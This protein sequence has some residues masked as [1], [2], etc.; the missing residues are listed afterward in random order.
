[1]WQPPGHIHSSVLAS[2]LVWHRRL[3]RSKP[4]RK[5]LAFSWSES[6][7]GVDRRRPRL[8]SPAGTRLFYTY[9]Q[10]TST[11]FD[12]FAHPASSLLHLHLPLIKP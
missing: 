6:L 5:C 8:R 1:L 4:S 12:F 10:E 2:G 3:D 9:Y 7:A 11:D